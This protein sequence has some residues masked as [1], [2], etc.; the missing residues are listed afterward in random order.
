VRYRSSTT[1]VLP[2]IS[3]DHTVYCISQRMT[4]S[5]QLDWPGKVAGATPDQACSGRSRMLRRACYPRSACL[6][7]TLTASY[8]AARALPHHTRGCA[9][10]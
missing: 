7:P 6:L 3:Y 9:A 2:D 4:P 10:V 8:P 1:A 5:R